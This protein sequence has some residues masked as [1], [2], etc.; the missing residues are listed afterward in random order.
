VWPVPQTEVCG[1]SIADKTRFII[2]LFKRYTIIKYL[3][4]I[5]YR[6]IFKNSIFLENSINEDLPLEYQQQQ[7][8]QHNYL[9]NTIFSNQQQQ[10]A[11]FKNPQCS[12][13]VLQH[14]SFICPLETEQYNPIPIEFN[15]QMSSS[16]SNV[17]SNNLD[18]GQN[19]WN[20]FE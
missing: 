15:Q 6:L 8:K 20:S 12:S 3:H 9:H 17:Y 13:Q 16:S 5:Y 19:L 14:S 11:L 1:N 4:K 2:T 7:P 18:L 10:Q